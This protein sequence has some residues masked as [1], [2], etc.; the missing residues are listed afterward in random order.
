MINAFLASPGHEADARRVFGE[1]QAVFAPIQQVIAAR[2]SRQGGPSP[3]PQ[4]SQEP[5]EETLPYALRLDALASRI[6]QASM[7][8]VAAEAELGAAFDA[9]QISPNDVYI[10]SEL[11][12][13]RASVD[14]ASVILRAT[15]NYAVASRLESAEYMPLRGRVAGILGQAILS[16]ALAGHDDPD[17]FRLAV[18]YL[19]ELFDASLA[20]TDPSGPRSAALVA[21]FLSTALG[22]A[23]E[24]EQSRELSRREIARLQAFVANQAAAEAAFQPLTTL[25]SCL[26]V[27][28]GNL[29]YIDDRFGDR[30]AAFDGHY[31]ALQWFL[32]AKEP[33]NVN[34]ALE[35]LARVGARTG[36]LD[37]ALEVV[38]TAAQ[39]M[40]EL[41]DSR[42]AIRLYLTIFE[43]NGRMGR[44]DRALDA[45]DRADQ[46]LEP[47]MSGEQ[48]DDDD[49]RLYA[50]FKLMAGV[51]WSLVLEAPGVTYE[52]VRGQLEEGRQAAVRL[53]E[54]DRIANLDLQIALLAREVGR[55]GDALA[56]VENAVR[57]EPS[58]ALLARANEVRAWILIDSG[59][60]AEAL[61]LLDSAV[62]AYEERSL[63]DR[64]MVAQQLRGRALE[65][66][67]RRTDAV[68]A[69][70]AAAAVLEQSRAALYEASRAEFV[71]N[72]VEI[73]DRLIW[74]LAL[75]EPNERI[76]ALDWVERSKSRTF[77]ELLGL[78]ELPFRG[79]AATDGELLSRE[80]ALLDQVNELRAHLFVRA[81]PGEDRLKDQLQ[82]HN[83]MEQLDS[84][85]T[86]LGVTNPAYVELRRGTSIDW[87]D[88]LALVDGGA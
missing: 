41:A 9:G 39:M 24:L 66:L 23:G 87:S 64:L 47:L 8:R 27:A 75:G 32:K 73:Y 74:L 78:G 46:L 80:H 35:Q 44:L 13:R 88:A 59:R 26:G 21:T 6:E 68:A 51:A 52:Y 15:L 57:A 40:E 86:T 69:Y 34:E 37:D 7:T 10:A 81:D 16:S 60:S 62:A 5:A 42:A 71:A 1:I 17:A 61:P 50:D 83:L 77:V 82:L 33:T 11:H 31:Q 72:G 2:Q 14:P 25:Y 30:D 36:R 19:Q 54:P 63:S 84:T 85:W 29:A 18:P 12:V 22:A 58:P 43:H 20:D 48:T 49:L 70:R 65:A 79:Q 76:E 28:Y 53:G 3:P 67:G 45:R 55:R 56:E 38:S 4:A